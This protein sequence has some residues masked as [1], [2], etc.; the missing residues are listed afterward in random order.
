MQNQSIYIT[1]IAGFIGF[2]LANRLHTLGAH[3]FGCDTFNAA[4]PPQIKY[5]RAERLKN[6]GISIHTLSIND[7]AGHQALFN[8]Q[9]PDIIIHLAAQAGVR[10]SLNQPQDFVTTNLAGFVELL[11]L[12]KLYPPKKF[13][14]ASSS[15][16]YG[17]NTH[18]PLSE[19]D[20]T[21]HPVSLYGATK[22]ANELIAYAYHTLLNIPMIGL[23]FFTC[24]GPFGRPDM[25]IFKFVKNITENQPITVYHEG[26]MK[27]DFTYVDDIVSGICNAIQHDCTFDVFNLGKGK[28]DD[29]N[30]L[31]HLIEKRLNKKAIID[32]QPRPKV[33]MPL[34]IADITKSHQILNFTPQ[35]SLEEGINRFI[36]WYLEYA[37]ISSN[38]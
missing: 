4:Y 24:Y 10:A 19:K 22:K 12:M 38:V 11:E 28:P 20:M 18:F 17:D 33:D 35:I 37:D 21:D 8:T 2:H 6:K 9:Q 25:A 27:R 32:Y 31:I 15:S 26:K 1:G 29:L 5:E 16:V 14:F 34:N 3:V 23:R 36:D 13:L 7:C 30:T